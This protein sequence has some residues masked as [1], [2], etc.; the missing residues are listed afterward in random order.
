MSN[1]CSARD[2]GDR[3]QP[4]P[5]ENAPTPDAPKADT[6]TDWDEWMEKHAERPQSRSDVAD[7]EGK[8]RNS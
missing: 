6:S 5:T 4:R 3:K 2:N 1:V 7:A 8:F